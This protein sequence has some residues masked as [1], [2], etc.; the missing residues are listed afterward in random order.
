M[1]SMSGTLKNSAPTSQKASWIYI[2]NTSY[3][4][5]ATRRNNRWL[6]WEM[7]KNHW[8]LHALWTEMQNALILKH[9]VQLWLRTQRCFKGLIKFILIKIFSTHSFVYISSKRNTLTVTFKT[10]GHDVIW[11]PIN[12]HFLQTLKRGETWHLI[13]V[14][15]KSNPGLK[16]KI[17]R[18]GWS[19]GGIWACILPKKNV[20]RSND[21]DQIGK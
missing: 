19:L 18:I 15:W 11:I 1:K 7:K 3:F 9:V 4:L 16:L 14:C 2:T 5:N 6:F 10:A 17:V 20:L 21:N 13:L 8:L 12:R